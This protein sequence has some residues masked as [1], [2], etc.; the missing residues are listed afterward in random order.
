MTSDTTST[1]TMGPSTVEPATQAFLD[2]L[3]AAGGPPIHT[4]P[5]EVAR[6]VLRD[7]QASVVLA[8]T[9]PTAVQDRTI[10]GGPTGEVALRLVKPLG[11][12]EP[13]PAVVYCHGGGWIL[14]DK[15]THLRLVQELAV[16]AR[17][18]VVFPDY[19]PAPEAQYP[20]QN[21]QAYTALEWVAEHGADLGVDNTRIALAGDSVGGNMVA[22]LSLMAK[23]RHGPKVAAQLLMYPVTDAS[24]DTESY[25]RFADGPWLT[26]AMMRWF[27]DAYLPD[28][29][30]RQE[31]T[32]SP[33]N[34]SLEQLRGL[35]PAMILTDEHDVLRDEGEAYA[36]KLAR[37]GVAVTAA[38][39]LGT[40]HD[41]AL[42]N[43]ITHTAPVRGAIAQARAYLRAALAA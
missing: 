16:G 43:P 6:Q 11:T 28:V 12:A 21:E 1:L 22:A 30:R 17:A 25:Q 41:F 31:P 27:W 14:G 10:R 26:R 33:L 8:H 7:L 34:A 5:P 38:R 9:P 39:F 2:E 35:P 42:L 3:A 32:A 20:A 4:L 40:I 24:F 18:L 29:E 15:D 19:T 23:D 13:M 37:A 36:H